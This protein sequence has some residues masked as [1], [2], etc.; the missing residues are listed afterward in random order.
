MRKYADIVKLAETS[1]AEEKNPP[2]FF[3]SLR[4]FA[5]PGLMMATSFF[6]REPNYVLRD[7]EVRAER[8]KGYSYGLSP[9][10]QSNFASNVSKK[11]GSGR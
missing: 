2:G 11:F 8:P 4:R 1:P 6:K 3:G 10:A 5:F 7:K 9:R